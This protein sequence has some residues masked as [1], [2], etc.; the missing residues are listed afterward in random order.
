MKKTNFHLTLKTAQ[1]LIKQELNLNAKFTVE[2]AGDGVYIYV[3]RMGFIE[4]TVSNDWYEHNGLISMNVRHNGIGMSMQMYFDP[5]TL[6]EDFEAEEKY[7]RDILDEFT[8][9]HDEVYR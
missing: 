8:A 2:R 9:R 5:D 7:R 6:Q 1:A 3:M 4:V